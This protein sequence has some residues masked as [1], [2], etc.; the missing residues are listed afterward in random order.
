LINAA[1]SLCKVSVL[2]VAIKPEINRNHDVKLVGL[3]RLEL[4]TSPLSERRAIAPQG[5]SKGVFARMVVLSPP[6][7]HL[8]KTL[9]LISYEFVLLQIL[10]N[11]AI[12]LIHTM[13]IT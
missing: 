1:E 9:H 7:P 12:L 8:L 13:V 6:F 4:P 2:I 5:Y 3:G 11:S 10:D